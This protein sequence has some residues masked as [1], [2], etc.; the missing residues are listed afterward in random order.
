MNKNLEKFVNCPKCQA[1]FKTI[2]NSLITCDSCNSSFK[3]YD[4]IVDFRD[5]ENHTTEGFSIKNDLA[6]SKILLENFNKFKTYNGLLWFLE[7]INN[8][9]YLDLIENETINQVLKDRVKFDIPMSKE[10]S[11]H[12]Y[13]ILNKI[14]LYRNEFNYHNYKK[15]VCLEN[16]AGHGLFVEGFS[17]NFNT[18]LVVDF[19]LSYLILIKKIC[20]E[21]NISNMFLLCANVEK[22]PFK[23]NL[24]DLVH[25]NNVIEHV[26]KQDKMINEINRVLSFEGLLF[27]LSP[28]KNSA[29]F[30][31][32]FTLPF[33]GF[34]PFKFR[35]WYIYKIQNRD[36]REVSLL[37][38][39]ELKN[40]F[41]DNF[42]G[43]FEISF[44]PSKLK[45]TAQKSLLRKIIIFFLSNKFFGSVVSYILNKILI[46]I[47]P[48]H[49][50]IA[51]KISRY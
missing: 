27:L 1:N 47:M 24:I 42:K 50:I 35:K 36:C 41:K 6:I 31:P 16:G 8:Y 34:L 29:Y 43:K 49:V 32:H 48:Y 51:K 40:I 18:V 14:D 26:T 46:S 44:I 28:N 23:N 45:V 33:Y 37:N 3:I 7:K 4:G 20:E 13:D 12:G 9:K 19:S 30:E 10:Q 39:K 15:N 21:K 11:I 22:L 25:S 5:I 38:F 17:K 2:D